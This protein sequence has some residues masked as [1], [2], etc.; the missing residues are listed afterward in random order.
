M[1]RCINQTLGGLYVDNNYISKRTLLHI[2]LFILILTS[3]FFACIIYDSNRTAK[4]ES[5]DV[6]RTVQ[7][8]ENSVQSAQEKV[9]NARDE[10]S[11]GQES[12]R[13]LKE[14]NQ[15]SGQLINECQRI[16]GN[17]Q[18]EFEDIDRANQRPNSQNI[19]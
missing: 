5:R 11:S 4:S 10:L 16:I 17:I 12:I 8:T 9:G 19:N 18:R 13:T 6:I 14:S 15:Q 2:V 1:P 7:S 3:I